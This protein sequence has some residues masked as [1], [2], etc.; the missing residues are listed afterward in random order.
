M[1]ILKQ[2]ALILGRQ[3]IDTFCV[4][5]QDS[6][7][8][9][10]ILNRTL[11]ENG[12]LLVLSDP[13]L[14][15]DDGEEQEVPG[16]CLDLVSC[17]PERYQEWTFWETAQDKTPWE[18]ARMVAEVQAYIDALDPQEFLP[19]VEAQVVAELEV[20]RNPDD[21]T[22]S[23]IDMTSEQGRYKI[24][25]K[26]DTGQSDGGFCSYV[27]NKSVFDVLMEAASV[28]LAPLNLNL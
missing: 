13:M 27:Y 19:Y 12:L 15:L 18:L 14:D 5:D 20:M 24:A 25:V 1:D 28:L 4:T 17:N 21:T 8:R 9:V 22:T 11:W 7:H 6:Y 16:Y 3:K 10:V 2:T 23:D 26:V